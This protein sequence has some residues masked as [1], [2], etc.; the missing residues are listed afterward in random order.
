MLTSSYRILSARNSIIFVAVLGFLSIRKLS[1]G[2]VSDGRGYEV[3]NRRR[4]VSALRMECLMLLGNFFMY[5]QLMVYY[6]KRDYDKLY[7]QAKTKLRAIA[8]ATLITFMVA[9][10]LIHFLYFASEEVQDQFFDVSAFLFGIWVNLLGLVAGCFIVN[11]VIRIFDKV[12]SIS[13]MLTRMRQLPYI[14]S[15]M[16]DRRCQIRA[17]LLVAVAMSLLMWYGSDDIV[18][19]QVTIPVK[20][21]SGLN[22]S[23]KIALLSDIHT[24]ATVRR[25]QIAKVADKLRDLD[26]DAVALVGDIVDG[27]L[28][29]LA[30]RIEPLWGALKQHHTYFV[31]GNHEYYYGDAMLWFA[32]YEAHGVR[33]LNNRC[34]MF[35]GICIVGVNDVSSN[36]SGIIG[37][38]M[39]LPEA[40]RNCTQGA[41]RLLL[42]HNPS[43]LSKFS[44]GDLAKIDV[45]L[46][47]HTHAGQFYVVAPVTWLLW[48]YLYGLYD[49]GHGKLFVSAGTLYGGPPMKMLWMSEIWIVNL[50]NDTSQVVDALR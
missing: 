43:S 8:S 35:H 41:S 39:N 45:V 37:H 9:A 27:P 13:P 36:K 49:I 31:S 6:E 32:E 11:S 42:T 18:V 38:H 29:I 23:V 46:S 24:G 33:V 14:S 17:V 1:A 44:A 15:L 12:P 47:G 21:F 5:G 22:G 4:F 50:V 28:K 3:G 20:N 34:E 26:V 48:P 40:M 30:N 7:K 10:Q 19:K 16:F 25:N 2:W